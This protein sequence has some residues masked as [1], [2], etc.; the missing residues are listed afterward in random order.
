MRSVF[1]MLLIS[2]FLSSCDPTVPNKPLCKELT[3]VRAYCVNTL[4]KTGFYWDDTELL[5]GKTYWEV[6]PKMLQVPPQTWK[7]LKA[8][9]IKSCKR[10]GGCKELEETLKSLDSNLI[11]I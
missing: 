7:E 8:Y 4:E 1:V 11:E 9:L 2:L 6:R 5:D 10:Q 3:P